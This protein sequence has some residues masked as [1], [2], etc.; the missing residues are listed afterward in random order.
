MR[1]EEPTADLHRLTGWALE[2]GVAL[3]DLE[4]VRPTLEDA[5]LDLVGGD[6]REGIDG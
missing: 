3:D 2:R 4:V 5:Y 6:P 1:T